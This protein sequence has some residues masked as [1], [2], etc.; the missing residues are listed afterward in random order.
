MRCINDSDIGTRLR[1]LRLDIGA[2]MIDIAVEFDISMAQYSRLESGKARITVDVLEKACKYYHSSINYI[3]FGEEQVHGSIFFP[4][5]QNFE[6]KDV[7]RFLKILTCLLDL[8]ALS[9]EEKNTPMYK[10]FAGGLLEMI[11]VTANNA[12]PYVLEYEKNIHR[13]SEN[14]MI[15]LLGLSRFKWNSIMHGTRVSDIMIPFVISQQF[16]YD[17]NFLIQNQI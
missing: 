17:L 2:K 14:D 10:M 1:E 3:L 6:E 15:R 11:P 8:D 12:M 9:E 13:K 5:L 7:R 4:K 16:G